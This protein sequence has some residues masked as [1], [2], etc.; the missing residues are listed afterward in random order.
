MDREKALE[1]A[2][3]QIE[4][5]YGKGAIMKLGE[6]EAQNQESKFS[7]RPCYKL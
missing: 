2:L 5:A 1:A 4:K 7:V 6:M 3:S